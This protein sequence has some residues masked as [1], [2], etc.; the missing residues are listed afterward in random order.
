LSIKP[1]KQSNK[2]DIMDIIQTF[3]S[4][5]FTK[6]I[7]IL[8]T[9][10]EPLFKA[11]DIAELLEI[12][13]IRKTLT[14]FDETE[15]VITKVNTQGGEQMATFLTENGLYRLLYK[16]NKPVAKCFRSWVK[17]VLREIR[18]TGRYE[19][20]K[21]IE[22]KYRQEID[23]MTEEL[24][25][26]KAQ[27]ESLE[28]ELEG[29]VETGP[30]IYIYQR[31]KYKENEKMTLKIG[32][33]KNLREREKTFKTVSPDGNMAFRIHCVPENLK[34][35]ESWIHCLLKP[36]RI[37]GE[38]F[39]MNYEF[40]KK[41]VIHVGNMIELSQTPNV[42][43]MEL[44]L[45]KIVDYE[46]FVLNKQIGGYA[47]RKEM[48]TQTEEECFEKPPEKPQLNIIELHSKFDRYINEC[49]QVDTFLEV[50]AKDI[51]GQ[52]RLWA[53]SADKETFHALNDYLQSRFKYVRLPV[54]N[55]NNVV[56]GFRGLKLKE[57]PQ[58]PLPFAPSDPE[59]FL[60][61]AC[62]FTPSG[63]ALMSDVVDEYQKWGNSIGKSVNYKDLKNYLKNSNRILV[64]NIWTDNGNGQGYYGL[65]FKGEEIVN[66]TSSTAKQVTKRN[67]NG[68][69]LATWTTIA[70]AALDEGIPATKLSRAIKNETIING[71]RYISS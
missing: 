71:F 17:E 29:Q 39:E 33:T 22:K 70:K 56:Y 12:N 52:Y 40:A 44:N 9:I 59:L 66:R 35:T 16:S 11:T 18:K 55:T 61:H 45:S 20:E 46:N 62:L 4:N 15:K 34:L 69:V 2:T 32:L 51:Q 3:H 47:S 67:E 30:F 53:R 68:D 24:T 14:E 1:N 21:E 57:I 49:C 65:S 38:V 8:G 7:T 6:Q 58:V 25:S 26:V 5:G 63:K 13:H 41:W 48:S 60:A 19:L 36:F 37:A 54:L 10:D 43:E 31:D 27:K 50:S 64:S 42:S 23:N 28:K